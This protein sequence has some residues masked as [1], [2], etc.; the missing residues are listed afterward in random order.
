ML[1]RNGLGVHKCLSDNILNWD[2]LE[3]IVANIEYY[4]TSG[5]LYNGKCQ[6]I[7]LFSVVVEESESVFHCGKKKKI[8]N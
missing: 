3:Y 2:G 6:L 7:H 8:G 4:L 5:F 1:H